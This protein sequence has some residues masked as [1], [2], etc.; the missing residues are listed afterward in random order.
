MMPLKFQRSSK[1][2][3]EYLCAYMLQQMVK[4]KKRESWTLKMLRD[5]Y[6]HQH[7]MYL[8]HRVGEEDRMPNVRSV[9]EINGKF[10]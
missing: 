4:S 9:E 1:R 3:E 2:I 7:Y 10:E 8:K 5:F 6:F